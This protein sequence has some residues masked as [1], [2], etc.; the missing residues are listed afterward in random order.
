MARPAKFTTED[1]LDGALR[2]VT[3]HGTSA[4]LAQVARRAG[5]EGREEA[6][7]QALELVW[8]LESTGENH[9]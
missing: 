3:A 7:R 2:A 6:Y 8:G 9:D 5:Q 4:T 1:L